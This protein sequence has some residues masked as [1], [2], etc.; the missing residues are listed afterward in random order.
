MVFSDQII[1]CRKRG[2]CECVCVCVCVCVW[3]LTIHRHLIYLCTIILLDI[4]Q[5]SNVIILDKIDG[6]TLSTIPTRTT[7]PV[8]RAHDSHMI[9]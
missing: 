3:S 2:V 8:N 6:H 9:C 7:N 4:T 5:D 1:N